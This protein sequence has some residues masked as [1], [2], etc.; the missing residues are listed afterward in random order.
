MLFSRVI[1]IG[2][3]EADYRLARY[4]DKDTDMPKTY[5]IKMIGRTDLPT[6]SASAAARN[7]N[8]PRTTSPL[9]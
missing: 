4:D 7:S 6:R 3:Y 9:K 1:S 2:V 8:M 5:C